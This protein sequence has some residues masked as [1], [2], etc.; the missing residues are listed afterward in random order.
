MKTALITSTGSVA[1]DIVIKSLKRLGMRT[2]GCNIYPKAWV[3][4]SCEVDVFKQ[5]PPICDSEKYLDAIKGICITEKVDFLLPMIDYEIDIFNEERDWFANN[6]IVLCMSPKNTIKIARDKKLL[7]DFI[8]ENCPETNSIPTA[9]LRDV[10]NIPS[11]FPVVC[12]PS[13]GRSSQGLRYIYNKTEWN[14]FVSGADKDIMIVEPFVEGSIVMV[15]VVR[16]A[17]TNQI[18][19]MVRRELTCTANG[20]STA[21]YIYDDKQLVKATAILA[22]KLGINGDVNFEY[23]QDENGKY[24]LVECNPRFSAGCEFAC[25]GG[26]DCVVNH[27]KC[28][29]GQAIDEYVF[30]HSMIISRKYEEYITEKNIKLAYVSKTYH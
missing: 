26:Y 2:I 30:K 18:A 20:C 17:D 13:N 14:E 9:Y 27:M 15:E 12:K 7:A 29:M 23:I 16:Q 28:F 8:K 3:V 19:C 4:E 22:E 21:V 11:Q 5:I 10:T 1:A 24:H 25:L 6:G